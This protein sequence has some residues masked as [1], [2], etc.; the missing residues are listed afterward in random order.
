VFEAFYKKDLAKRLLLGKSASFDA[1]KSM[2]LKLKQECG[3]NFTSKLE[4]MFKDMELSREMMVN[5]R[6]LPRHRV[7]GNIELN[8]NVLTMGYWPT[9]TPMEIILP[10]EMCQYREA[11]KTFY[12]SKHSGRR[13]QWQP[14]LGHCVLKAS[15]PHGDKELQ[16]SLFQSLVLL[17]FNSTDKQS[18][19]YIKEATSIEDGELRRTLQSLSLGKA[20]V[21]NKYPKAKEVEDSDEFVYNADFKHKMCRIKINQVQMKETTE[22]NTAT[23]ERVFQDRQYQVVNTY[24]PTQLTIVLGNDLFM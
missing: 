17:L 18:F 15:F 6:E 20:R 13:L 22:E 3:A 12:L 14:S 19:T 16:V 1:E 7:S 10:P 2:L 5:F 4:G 8:V 9:Y 11:F 21:L 23:N 24:I